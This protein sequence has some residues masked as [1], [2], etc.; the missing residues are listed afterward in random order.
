[1]PKIIVDRR[2][3]IAGAVAASLAVSAQAQS[4]G[5][6][7]V[8]AQLALADQFNVA[9]K[10]TGRTYRIYTSRPA[11]P[12]PTAGYQVVYTLDGDSSFPI[13]I[14]QLRRSPPL[15]VLLVG[16]AYPDSASWSRLRSW[17]LTPSQPDAFSRLSTPP[18]AAGAEFGGADAFHRFM[19]EELQPQLARIYPLDP[20]HQSLMGYSLGG[21]F[22][23]HVMFAHPNLYQGLFIGSPS[24][25]WN[26]REVLKGEAGFAAAVRAGTAAPRIL[27]TS[28]EWEQ[29]EGDS[30]A[31]RT[32]PVLQR[33]NHSRMV[34]NAR[35]LAGRLKALK[36][37]A[38]YQV[39][40]VVFAEETHVGGMPAAYSRGANFLY[41]PSY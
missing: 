10:I 26:E 37:A 9:S 32:G 34:D 2:G 40:Y 28:A 38:G 33:S 3:L 27:I 36:G 21:L 20:Q 23:L 4:A 5:P 16:I 22:A 31:P 13:V 29:G 35:E 8:P 7:L 19:T 25:W 24:I 12:P 6:K 17:D 18:D 14:R 15:P 39:D 41:P 11:A 30:R 1:M